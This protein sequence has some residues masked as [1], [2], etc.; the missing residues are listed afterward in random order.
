MFRQSK[1]FGRPVW[2]DSREKNSADASG[3][4]PT[5][6]CN[7]HRRIVSC[8][9]SG[10]RRVRPVGRRL[11]DPQIASSWPKT[12][13]DNP[14]CLHPAAWARA[15]A[16]ETGSQCVAVGVRVMVRTE[17][18]RIQSARH[19]VDHGT[20]S[21]RSALIRDTPSHYSPVLIAPFVNLGRRRDGAEI[22]FWTADGG[23]TRRPSLS[24]SSAALL[25]CHDRSQGRTAERRM[26]D[27][28][29]AVRR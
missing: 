18:L 5:K 16:G 15:T 9:L 1:E 28:N 11:V 8:M 12:V 24:T 7:H 3:A 2:R 21:G 4:V 26:R 17:S 19:R 29:F 20:I 25:T 10:A 14:Q 27:L 6:R 13:N 22:F 23:R